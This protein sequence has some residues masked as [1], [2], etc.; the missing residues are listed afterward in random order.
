MI[1][2]IT[3]V[4]LIISITYA[5]KKI[6]SKPKFL[7]LIV[8]IGVLYLI[9][10]GKAHWISAVVVA[11]IPVIKKLFIIFRY[12]PIIK[13][14][15]SGYQNR[16]QQKKS[17]EMSRKEAADILGISEN[18]SKQEIIFA[19]KKEMQKHHPDKGGSK[20]MASKINAAKDI[21]LS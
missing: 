1:Y 15:T 19:H 12:L 18:S 3:I 16:N 4:L 6:K 11:L 13:R 8:L 9:A 5:S 2:L 10:I 17:Y 14:F 20:D 21:L 7:F